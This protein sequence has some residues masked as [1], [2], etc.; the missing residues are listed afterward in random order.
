V[1]AV[2]AEAIEQAVVA[3]PPVLD[4]GP[5][6]LDRDAFQTVTLRNV[7]TE[8]AQVTGFALD[9]TDAG[10]TLPAGPGAFPLTLAPGE[11]RQ[12][13]FRFA[14]GHQGWAQDVARFQV[15]SRRHPTTNVGL[16]GHGG[17]PELCISPVSYDYGNQPVGS[18]TGVTVHI[19]NCGSGNGGPMV[20]QSFDFDGT[21]TSDAQFNF[22]AGTFP[23]TLLP[24]EETTV[25]VFYEPERDGDHA[26]VFR[27]TS[28][29]YNGN[30]VRLTFRGNATV[31]APCDLAVTPLA[32]DFGTIVPGRGAV[33]GVKLENRGSDVCA[34]KNMKLLDDA[35]GVFNMPGGALDGFVIYPGN[36]FSF[37][38]GATVPSAGGVFDGVL[39]IEQ[40]NPATPQV[41]VP[42][43]VNGQ[44]SCLVAQ[45]RY[46]DFGL[47]RAD[48]PPDAR[49]VNFLN[50]C[51]EPVTVN[52]VRIGAGTTDGEFVITDAPATFP[53]TLAPGDSFSVEVDYEA[54]VAGM[55]LSPLFADVVGLPAPLEVTLLGE[56]S[57]RVEKTDRFVQTDG[58][59]VDVMFVVDNTAS[60]VEEQPRFARA[61]PAFAD[62][63][64]SAGVD[65]H[66]GVTTTGIQAVSNACPGGAQGGEA[67][68]F[69]PA[70]NSNERMMTHLTPGLGAELS[71][72]ANVGQ[73]AIVEQG[74]E[75]VRRAL[76]DPL[77]SR[78]DDPRTGLPNDGNAGFLRTDAT[79]LLVFVGD[80]DDN[81]PDDVA[82]YVRFLQTTKGESQPQRVTAFAIAPTD[83][84]CNT[85]G[86]SGSRYADLA[87][88]TG[89][90][91]LDICA[92]DYAPLLRTVAN[93]AFNPQDR[94][95]LSELPEVAS[96]Q[97]RV[98]GVL[99]TSGWSYDSTGNAIVFST[100]P[101]PGAAIEVFYRR[102]CP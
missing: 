74:F 46:L 25:R 7:S 10:F 12:H 4:F 30:G 43:R 85:A 92:S 3:E 59:K 87:R 94:F 11:T 42:L 64:L 96:I 34:V 82:T 41:L 44:T 6:P 67:G 101:P 61:L 45:P 62:A 57:N 99:Q 77:V 47:A 70:D 9:G 63:A 56:S 35:D 22:Q 5:V 1:V 102:A 37:Q 88:R 91:V 78:A 58:R 13:Q 93:R 14:P 71:Q 39:Q 55:N 75:A 83:R 89:G 68:R 97:V 81:S 20:L 49:E 36:Y 16:Q 76:S 15:V 72:N 32:V 69:F 52:G 84:V 8:P 27:L 54:Q 65:L 40:A 95:P 79:L 60:M 19:K 100:R 90:E 29:A 28:S 26:T 98:N 51:S 66:V 21:G 86:G 73:C 50:A 53:R 17:A 24:G 23:R 33:L 48:C 38:V 2:S 80:E 18:R 31:R